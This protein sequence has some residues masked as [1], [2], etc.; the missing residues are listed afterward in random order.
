MLEG[1]IR[2][3]LTNS[4]LVISNLKI[5]GRRV[6]VRNPFAVLVAF[7]EI[8]KDNEDQYTKHRHYRDF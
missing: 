5:G 3:L 8:G 2:N 1:V 6:G 7:G 4:L